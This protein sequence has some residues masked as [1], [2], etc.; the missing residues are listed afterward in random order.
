MPPQDDTIRAY[1]V[2]CRG[3]EARGRA[4]V[5]VKWAR[6]RRTATHRPGR[7]RPPICQ[8]PPYQIRWPT[9]CEATRGRSCG[10]LLRGLQ[11]PPLLLG[12][13][14]PL[15]GARCGGFAFGAERFAIGT[16]P[17]HRLRAPGVALFKARQHIAREQFVGALGRLP[18]GPVMGEHQNAAKTTRFGPVV[19]QYAQCVVGRANGAAPAFVDLL[20]ARHADR[21]TTLGI[22]RIRVELPLLEAGADIVDRLLS[23]LGDME[24]R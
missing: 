15:D 23:R 3:C 8:S 24:W 16:H 4:V 11:L 22:D 20:D 19:L 2:R 21:G 17:V 13:E 5:S 9:L 12:G 10:A 7:C 18:I 6:A 14:V 1:R